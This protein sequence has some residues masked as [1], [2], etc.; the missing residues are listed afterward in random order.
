MIAVADWELITKS[1]GRSFIAFDDS[2]R[3]RVSHTLQRTSALA[4]ITS[5]MILEADVEVLPSIESTVDA[6][7]A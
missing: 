7:F 4:V 2:R 6:C 3:G 5:I 1:S